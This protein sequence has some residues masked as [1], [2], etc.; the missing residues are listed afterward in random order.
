VVPSDRE[1]KLEREVDQLKKDM[2]EISVGV[3][4]MVT[5]AYAKEKEFVEQKRARISTRQSII[6]ETLMQHIRFGQRPR[7]EEEVQEYR[8]LMIA[9]AKS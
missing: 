8:D 6:L 9:L 7:T 4:A 3:T 5:R 2:L 1:F